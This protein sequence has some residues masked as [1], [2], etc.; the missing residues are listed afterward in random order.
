MLFK[1]VYHLVFLLEPLFLLFL[2]IQKHVTHLCLSLI[3]KDL[4]L[5]FMF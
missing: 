1:T 2:E 5:L 3:R 4:N